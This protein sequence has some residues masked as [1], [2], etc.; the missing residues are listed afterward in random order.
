MSLFWIK[1][2]AGFPDFLLAVKVHQAFTHDREGWSQKD[3][4]GFKLGLE[5]LRAEGRLATLLFQ[6]PWSFHH[7]GP[8]ADYLAR[9][10]QAFSGY[11]MTVEVRHSSWDRPDF[12][13]FL[14]QHRVC[15]CNIDQPVIGNSIG[16]NP[17]RR[18]RGFGHP[19]TKQKKTP[20][21]VRKSPRGGAGK[22]SSPWGV[23][24]GGAKGAP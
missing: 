12:Y 14:S 16:P 7:S 11:P 22:F 10:F 19:L 23:P 5:P 24:K 15:F 3:A 1:K 18:A 13:G 20:G 8:N 9:L 17:P 21:P 2:L 6:F 4:D